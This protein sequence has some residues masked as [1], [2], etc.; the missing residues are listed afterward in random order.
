MRALAFTNALKAGW[1]A[2]LSENHAE[3]SDTATKKTLN[4]LKKNKKLSDEIVSN[5]RQV[6]VNLYGLTDSEAS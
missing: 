1:Q 2:S 6:A 5:A 3:A 4:E